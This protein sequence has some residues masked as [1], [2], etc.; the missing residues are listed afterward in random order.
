MR[1]LNIWTS[2]S[3]TSMRCFSVLNS[4]CASRRKDVHFFNISTSKSAPNPLCFLHCDVH[5]CL[6]PQRHALFE[7]VNFQQ[8]YGHVAL[9]AFWL[10]NLLRA[11]A[12]CN[13]SLSSDQMAPHR[14][15]WR[16]Y[17]SSLRS[18][19]NTVFRN[20]SPFSCT[21]IFFL[22]TLSLLWSSF[23]FSSLLWLFPPLLF[24]LLSEFW[25]PNFLLLD[26]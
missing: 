26:G 12:A 14:P 20:F 13:Y 15:L 6:A 7:H 23:F 1:F 9:F 8:C 25:L 24:H 2:R 10:R 17:F 19:K 16:A 21:F 22:L 18:P 3:A 11:T 5:M 4:K